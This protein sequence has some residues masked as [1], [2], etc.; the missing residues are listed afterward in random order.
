LLE[1]GLQLADHAGL[2]STGDD[3]GPRR[4]AFAADLKS[5]LKDIDVVE[6]SALAVF[7]RLMTQ[8]IRSENT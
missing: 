4:R 1:T 7:R 3:V 6:A 8:T 5:I 2:T